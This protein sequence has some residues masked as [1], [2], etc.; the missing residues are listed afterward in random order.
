MPEKHAARGSLSRGT[1]NKYESTEREQVPPKT[2]Q[3]SPPCIYL[4]FYCD[5][6]SCSIISAFFA[7]FLL[8]TT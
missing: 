3:L 8:T 7:H 5:F 4:N 1:W 2:A 6:L